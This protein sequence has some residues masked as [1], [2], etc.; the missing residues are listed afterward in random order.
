M[1]LSSRF[2]VLLHFLVWL[3]LGPAAAQ[4]PARAPSDLRWAASWAAAP[5]DHVQAPA[6]GAALSLDGQTLRQRLQP[7]LGGARA[8]IRF[9]NR[10]GKL[11]LRIAG[12]SVAISTGE[13]A[14]SPATLRPLRFAGGGSITI[15]PGAE[16]W[17]DAA[18]I[19][20]DPG[21]AIAVSFRFEGHAPVATVHH[22]P[23]NATWMLPGDAVMRPVWRDAV[24]SQ[25]NH[26]VTGLDVYGAAARRVVVAFGDSITEGAGADERQAVSARYPDRL[27]LRL[28][29]GPGSAHAFGVINA[30]I[31]GNRLL[32]SPA[33]PPGIERFEHDV[34]AQSGVT[35][36]LIL[37]GINDIGLGES[38]GSGQITAGLQRLV[39]Q[40]HARGVK[41]L[42]GTLPPFKG[43]PYWSEAKEQQRQAVN[44]WVRGRQDIDAVVDFDAVLRDPADPLVL[45][46]LYDSGDRL[47]PGNAGY[48]AMADAIDLRELQE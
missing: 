35:H 5:Q 25:W 42:L 36:A 30:G 37:L 19:E 18:R 28:R 44:R 40:A 4:T 39:A 7:T 11:P 9:S 26:V 43:A 45:N 29:S 8:R 41:V 3:A 22:L 12:A 48:A 2:F 31:S 10:F 24:P 14:V 27:A 46:S 13:D 32:A 21:Q 34:L 38:L 15:A 23:Q 20:V 17:S 33:G 47:H 6:P 1:T 16:A